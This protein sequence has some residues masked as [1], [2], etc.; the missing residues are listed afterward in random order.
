MADTDA[1]A[2]LAIYGEG[3]A[4]GHAT[5]QETVPSWADWDTGHLAACRLVAEDADGLLGWAALSAVSGRCIYAGVCEVSLYMAARARGRGIGR[6]LLGRLVADSEA[7]GIWTLQAG[8]FP[9]N[10]ASVAVHRAAGFALVG[11]RV[12]LGRMGFGPMAGCWRDVLLLERR[13]PAVGAD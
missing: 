11:R 1:A 3:I 9:E 7:N 10:A 13:S 6:R 8:I 5:F 2:V 4:T 12:R